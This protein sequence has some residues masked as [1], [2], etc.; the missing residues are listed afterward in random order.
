MPIDLRLSIVVI[1]NICKSKL[2]YRINTNIYLYDLYSFDIR[3]DCFFT[4]AVRSRIV[5]FILDRQRFPAKSHTD[6]AFGIERLIAEGVYT[7]AYP[8]HDVRSIYL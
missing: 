2:K 6:M 5:E 1:R 8:L 4:T 3:Q 7:A